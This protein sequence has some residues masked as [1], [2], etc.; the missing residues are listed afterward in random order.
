MQD[1]NDSHD[2]SGLLPE[3]CKDLIDVL[4]IPHQASYAALTAQT[5]LWKF[6]LNRRITADPVRLVD[7]IGLSDLVMPLAHALEL[8]QGQGWDLV[9]IEPSASPPVC[10]SVDYGRFCWVANAITKQVLQQMKGPA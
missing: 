4:K 6:R 9:E 2:R 5:Q 8:A 3:G 1:S 10:I 7:L